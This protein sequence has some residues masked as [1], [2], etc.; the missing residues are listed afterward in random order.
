MSNVIWQKATLILTINTRSQYTTH[1][2][3]R[4]APATYTARGTTISRRRGSTGGFLQALPI[5]SSVKIRVLPRVGSFGLLRQRADLTILSR[6][7]LGAG[8]DL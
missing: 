8:V 1:P 5:R 2:A 4:I 7:N 3:I 6:L